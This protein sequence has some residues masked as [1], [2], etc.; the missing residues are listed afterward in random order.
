MGESFVNSGDFK[1]ELHKGSDNGDHGILFHATDPTVGEEVEYPDFTETFSYG[2]DTYGKDYRDES[3]EISE[4]SMYGL[5]VGFAVT[6]IFI[7]F[8]L[9]NIVIDEVQ[10][11]ADFTNKVE[12][13]LDALRAE[14]YNYSEDAIRALEEEFAVRD[15]QDEA[16]ALEAERKELAEIN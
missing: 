11:H 5:I 13:S 9:I 7:I 4:M 2:A 1:R 14:P 12:T 8:A 6:F 10:R 15:A 16:A 3:W